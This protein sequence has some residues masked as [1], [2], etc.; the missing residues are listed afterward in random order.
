MS[1]MCITVTNL[2]Q[3]NKTLKENSYLWH[4]RMFKNILNIQ[5]GEITHRIIDFIWI[6]WNIDGK[7][8][9]L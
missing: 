2:L 7:S 5:Q 9:M 1:N 8:A 3:K 6:R 4:T